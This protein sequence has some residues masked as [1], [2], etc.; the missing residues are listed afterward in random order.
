MTLVLAEFSAPWSRS[1]RVATVAS[2]AGLSVMVLAGLF[3]GPQQL[4]VWRGALGGVALVVLLA[5]LPFMVGGYVLTERHIEVRRL[6]W[7]SLLP[8]AGVGAVTEIGRAGG[9]GGGWGG[10]VVV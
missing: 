7:R 2:V 4:A 10:G 3:A 8:L 1:V 5:T 9:W 6:G